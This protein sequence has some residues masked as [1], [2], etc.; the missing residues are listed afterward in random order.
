LSDLRATFGESLEIFGKWSKIF[1]KLPK[2]P[3][4]IIITF[5]IKRKLPGGLEIGIVSYNVKKYFNISMCSLVKIFQHS[6]RNFVSLR[7]HVISSIS[8]PGE[9]IQNKNRQHP[10]NQSTASKQ[11]W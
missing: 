9:F 7:S 1:R 5:V 3:F 4:S 6:K 10:I 8:S 11:L 2:A